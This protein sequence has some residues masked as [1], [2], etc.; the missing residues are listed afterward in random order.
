MNDDNPLRTRNDWLEL[1]LYLA[2]GFGS[3]ITISLLISELWPQVVETAVYVLYLVNIICFTGTTY[4]LGIR[5]GKITWEG[6][7]LRPFK[8]QWQWP[9]IGVGVAV[10][11]LP[12]RGAIGLIVQMLLAGNMDSIEARSELIM[13]MGFSWA[14]F[15][16][17]LVGVGVLV[18]IAEELFFRGL[19]HSWFQKHM[20]TVWLRILLSGLI[21]AVGHADSIGVVAASFV[22]GV[23]S[24]LFFERTRSL[25]IP[26]IIHITTN[27][28]ATILLFMARALLAYF[29]ELA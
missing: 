23:V 25:T 26:I 3:F 15:G 21:F 28:T 14:E 24:P 12:V 19:I 20:S 17:T 16:I 5:R 27:S 9:L 4:L 6:L 7:G 2:V 1:L 11:L 13:G 10:V 8:W 29:P 22:I 18:P